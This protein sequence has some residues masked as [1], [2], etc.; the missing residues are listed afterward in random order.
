MDDVID[1][2]ICALKTDKMPEYLHL[3][4]E[5]L[6]PNKEIVNFLKEKLPDNY[7]EIGPGS[8]PFTLQAPIR[9]PLVSE[10]KEQIG[11][12]PKADFKQSLET[13]FH[14]MK[15]KLQKRSGTE[16]QISNL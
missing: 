5:K 6:Y 8:E 16:N 11:F 3:S 1:G 9:G 10:Y 2:I 15:D 7:I 4:S 14:W 12:Q 13:Y